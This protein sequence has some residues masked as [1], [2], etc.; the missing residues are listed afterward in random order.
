MIFHIFKFSPLDL[1]SDVNPLSRPRHHVFVEK[2]RES[3][4]TT[5]SSEITKE[6][7]SHLNDQRILV[8]YTSWWFQPIWK[9]LVKMG[10]FPK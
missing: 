2:W 4:G 5:Q 3:D 10:I 7:Q 8:K 6:G 1:I 9:I